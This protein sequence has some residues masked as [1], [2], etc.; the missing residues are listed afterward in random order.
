MSRTLLSLYRLDRAALRTFEARLR[1]SLAEDNR[2]SLVSLLGL[3]GDL[4]GRI[5]RAPYAVDPFL[6]PDTYP[7]SAPLFA[8]LR[9][10]AKQCALSLVWTS[11][12]PALEGRL[13]AFDGIREDPA[14]ARLADALLDK[15]RVPWFLRRQGSTCGVLTPSECGV[16]AHGLEA[17]DEPPPELLALAQAL[18]EWEGEVLCHDTLS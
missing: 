5:E 7:P 14:L 8:A 12:S 11:D 2:P 10:V 18:G 13:Q 1:E 17:L 16:L 6:A 15:G 3:H 4:A 9:R